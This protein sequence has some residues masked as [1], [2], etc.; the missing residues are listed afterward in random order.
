MKETLRN[1][2][3][4]MCVVSISLIA[5]T[6]ASAGQKHG[7]T[8]RIVASGN[9][10]N[11]DPHLSASYKTGEPCSFVYS[12]LATA[13]W[14]PEWQWDG[15]W[16]PVKYLKGDMAESWEQVDP[17][18]IIIQLRKGV[19]F[20]NKAPVNGREMVASD[21]KYSIERRKNSKYLGH[22]I[23]SRIS[24][25]EAIDRYRVKITYKEPFSPALQR[26]LTNIGNYIIPKEAVEEFG[27]LSKP[28][29]VIGT[30]PFML[31]KYIPGSLMKFEKNPDFYLED[32]PYVDHVEF[33]IMPDVQ[34]RL[35]ALRTGNLDIVFDVPPQV[36]DD[37]V[38][39]NPHFKYKK[40][41]R[42]PFVVY[43]R[44]DEKPFNDVRVRRAVTLAVDRKTLRDKFWGGHAEVNGYPLPKYI[45]EWKSSLQELGDAAKYL[46]Y[47]PK[48]AKRL[49]TEAGYPEGFETNLTTTAGY[50][51]IF[52][53]EMEAVK[54]ML[55]K[56]GIQVQ[57]IVKDYVGYYSTA[58]K[59]KYHGMGA[60][61]HGQDCF[62]T[63]WRY[64]TA[65]DPQRNKAHVNDPVFEDLLDKYVVTFNEDEQKRIVKKMEKRI[66]SQCYE[67]PIPLPY[68]FTIWNPRVKN[69]NGERY[70][71]L[72]GLGM[73]ASKV[74][75][76]SK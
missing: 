17:K 43:M 59:G 14:S 66:I 62:I 2:L 61:L 37:F 50:G 53:E 42:V 41:P 56:V 49:L 6:S 16:I 40:G 75:L 36:A 38:K 19:K 74:W 18:T 67:L 65:R 46:E 7:G 5:F 13:S 55:S 28:E 54:D 1:I 51:K 71:N 63:I 25:V 21:L 26:L 34:S 4:G 52:V 76:E 20:H 39:S 12:K 22:F 31:E 60:G 24:N 15:Y 73:L 45:G 8:L 27:D 57:L 11:W 44:N 33:L 9:P 68:G 70:D 58:H 64:Y 10:S 32:M 23:D 30:G 3:L 35:A 69:Y 48:E 47:D 72:Y 29:H